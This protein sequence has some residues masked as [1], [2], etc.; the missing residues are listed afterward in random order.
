MDFANS[1]KIKQ[2]FA[3]SSQSPTVPAEGT[4]AMTGIWKHDHM[5]SVSCI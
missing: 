2:T 4:D 5:G 1:F 3:S